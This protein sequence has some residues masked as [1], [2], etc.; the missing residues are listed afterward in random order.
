VSFEH[1]L[2][3]ANAGAETAAGAT[4]AVSVESGLELTAT[5]TTAGECGVAGQT[6]SCDLGDLGGGA[7]E[8][9]TLT[10]RGT[11][12]G[13][14]AIDAQA[15]AVD[16]SAPGNDA[17]SHLVTI[18]PAVNL[19][20]AANGRPLQTGQQTT[21]PVTLSNA[22]D[23]GASTVLVAVTLTSGLRADSATLAGAACS[24]AG[25]SLS[26]PVQSLD[27]RQST[28]LQLTV[29]ALV[30]GAQQVTLDASS[31]EAELAPADNHLLLAIGVTEPVV[32]AADG[33]GGAIAWQWLV[34]L[35]LL[36]RARRRT[37]T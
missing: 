10:L 26:C 16:D 5:R 3:V 15:A 4:L 6:V 8:I 36:V 24:I 12:V 33:G 25:Q 22:A 20:L 29:T 19:G 23:L 7:A 17:A 9:V 34:A 14:F 11:A 28:T 2:R 13:S 32:A 1:V 30:A 35:G 37:R 21:L 27:A 31:A 18:A